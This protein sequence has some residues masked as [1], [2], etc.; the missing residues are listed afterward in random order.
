MFLSQISINRPVLTVMM[1][2]A[3]VLFGIIGLLRL[4]VRE[5]PNIDPP[6]VSVMTIYP[7]ANA[8]VVETEVTERLEEELN[9]IEGIKTLTSARARKRS[10][11]SRLSSISRGRWMWRRRMCATAF[12]APAASCRRTSRSRSSPS[13]KPMRSRS[14]GS[15]CT[16]IATTR[17]NFRAS[18]NGSSRTCCRRSPAFRRSSSAARSAS[19]SASGSTPQRWPRGRSP[20]R[21]SSAR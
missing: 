9:S 4:P 17:S 20:C 12:R 3:L 1:S 5:L 21:M 14:C 7:G 18:P 16:A 11:I 15:R 19:P 13:R 6:I 8:Q 2:L 10:A